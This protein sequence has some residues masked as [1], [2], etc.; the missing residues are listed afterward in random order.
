MVR[1]SSRGCSFF[2]HPC[3]RPFPWAVHICLHTHTIACAALGHPIQQCCPNV[4]RLPIFHS[5]CTVIHFPSS[6][7][8]CPI[9][10]VHERLPCQSSHWIFQYYI[11]AIALVLDQC[12]NETPSCRASQQL[13]FSWSPLLFCMILEILVVC[14]ELCDLCSGTVWIRM[15]LLHQWVNRFRMEVTKET[16]QLG[17]TL[18]TLCILCL[19]H[20]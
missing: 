14:P 5:I 11:I 8:I 17:S 20:K 19:Q 9:S 4:R 18:L 7:P 12:Y 13:L 1:W 15:S 10:L 2:A 16:L 6:H 3:G